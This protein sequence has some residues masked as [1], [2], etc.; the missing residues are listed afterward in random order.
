MV[1][2]VEGPANLYRAFDPSPGT[3]MVTVQDGVADTVC[4]VPSKMIFDGLTSHPLRVPVPIGPPAMEI[5]VCTVT[6]AITVTVVDAVLPDASW[7][8]TL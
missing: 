3:V 7:A 2:V 4:G 6:E 1:V 5:L 8:D